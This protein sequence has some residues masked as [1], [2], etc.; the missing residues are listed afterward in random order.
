L[1]ILD[2]RLSLA[3]NRQW[4]IDPILCLGRILRR[5]LV[6][7]LRQKL[8]LRLDNS[9]LIKLGLK[10][11]GQIIDDLIRLRRWEDFGT[12][13]LGQRLATGFSGQTNDGLVDCVRSL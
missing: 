12:L 3:L 2:Q 5:E 6:E 9:Q 11:F 8:L 1:N 4:F 7:R 10:L 13:R